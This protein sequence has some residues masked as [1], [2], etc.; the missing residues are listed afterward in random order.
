MR[1]M[2]SVAAASLYASQQRG[3]KERESL[4]GCAPER[5]LCVGSGEVSTYVVTPRLVERFTLV[6]RSSHPTD[7]DWQDGIKE[8]GCDPA[9]R[10]I[11]IFAFVRARLACYGTKAVT[12]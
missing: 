12:S 3:D 2:V 11:N 10:K 8:T 1:E 7:R 6:C 9:S 4:R 5:S